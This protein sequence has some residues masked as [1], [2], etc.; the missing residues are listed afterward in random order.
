S[1]MFEDICERFE[2]WSEDQDGSFTDF[3][4]GYQSESEGRNYIATW[5][6]HYEPFDMNLLPN[7]DWVQS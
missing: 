4:T 2:D 1:D 7:C 5:D 6:R 3:V